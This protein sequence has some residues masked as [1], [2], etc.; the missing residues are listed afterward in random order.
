[1]TSRASSILFAVLQGIS[2]RR[3]LSVFLQV[4]ETGTGRGAAKQLPDVA[5]RVHVE[6]ARD[7][8]PGD[9]GYGPPSQPTTKEHG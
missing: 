5:L 6:E 9:G 8:M 3:P 7:A 2:E 1:M 4:L